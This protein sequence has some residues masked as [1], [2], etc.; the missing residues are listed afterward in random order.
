MVYI[1]L[2]S[3]PDLLGKVFW[4]KWSLGLVPKGRNE[5]LQDW[6]HTVSWVKHEAV[7]CRLYQLK[8]AG[9]C[10]KEMRV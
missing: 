6:S 4:K 1:Q 9:F 5:L 3:E 8:M 2:G 10:E 7:E